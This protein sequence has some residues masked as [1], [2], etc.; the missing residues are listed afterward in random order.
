MSLCRGVTLHKYLHYDTYVKPNFDWIIDIAT[1]ITQGMGF[2]HSKQIIHKNLKSRN[3]FIDDDCK[4]VITDFGLYSI[5][6]K[7]SKS[8]KKELMALKKECIYYMAPE[9]VRVLGSVK[10]E[11]YF[12]Y[13][14]DVFSFGYT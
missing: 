10:F 6:Q 9:L 4:A 7:M 12:S 5:Y 14:T 1:Q 3:I 2:L 8:K 11:T 13:K